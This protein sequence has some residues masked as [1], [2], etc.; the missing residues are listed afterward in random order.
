MEVVRRF[1]QYVL[2]IVLLSPFAVFGQA[3]TEGEKGELVGQLGF[4]AMTIDAYYEICYS[5]G[6]RTDNNLSG[7]E[8]LVSAKWGVSY[9]EFSRHSEMM[10]GRNYRNEAHK[11]VHH[12]IQ[13]NGGCATVGMQKWFEWFQRIHEANLTKF[14]AA[15]R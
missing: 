13:K 14:Q 7:I 10:S 5:R 15:P 4:G 12:A 3:F 11:L 9:L 8:R 2:L 1:H 6:H